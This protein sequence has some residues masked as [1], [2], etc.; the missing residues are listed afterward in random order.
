M[1]KLIKSIK[2]AFNT[3]PMPHLFNV[4]KQLA[5]HEYQDISEIV[6]KHWSTLEGSFLEKN[7]E[8][9]FWLSPE[10]FCYYLPGILSASIQEDNPNLIINRSIISM[11]DRSSDTGLWDDF[12]TERWLLLS[13]EEC[14]AVQQ[15]ILWL[16]NHED[17]PFDDSSLSRAFDTLSLLKKH[18]ISKKNENP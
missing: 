9:I 14:S 15:W 8:S 13:E 4:P 10:A 5:T 6:G 18:Q 1:I 17:S 16:L 12:F 3:R 2:D 11:L 7:F